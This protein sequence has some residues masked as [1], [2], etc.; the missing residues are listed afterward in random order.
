MGKCINHP[1]R[2]T[3]FFCMK[4]Q[5]YLCEECLVCKDPQLYCKHRSSCPIWFMTKRQELWDKEEQ[6]EAAAACRITFQPDGQTV[7]MP[8]G[9]TLLDA[10][11][12]ADSACSLR[13][14]R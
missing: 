9:S 8:L 12:A 2:E 13:A 4:H 5:L 6:H 11:Q 14:V 1:D 7:R 10:A 3:R